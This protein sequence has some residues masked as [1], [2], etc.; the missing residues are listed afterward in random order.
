[1]LLIIISTKA[2]FFFVFVFLLHSHKITD[3]TYALILFL[4]RDRSSSSSLSSFSFSVCFSF[5][6]LNWYVFLLFI[7]EL[8]IIKNIIGFLSLSLSPYRQVRETIVDFRF[9]F[10]SLTKGQARHTNR[11]NQMRIC[12]NRITLT[13]TDIS[14]YTL[15]D[16]SYYF[17]YCSFAS[18]TSKNIN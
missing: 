12:T 15:D 5:I 18:Q 10:L 3:M 8:K 7:F 11:S 14:I 6:C 4:T 16:Y 13:M 1:M 17:Y 2:F 9:F